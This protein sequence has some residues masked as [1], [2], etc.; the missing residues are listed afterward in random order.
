MRHFPTMLREGP[1]Q[2]AKA[3][4]KTAEAIIINRDLCRTKTNGMTGG[5]SILRGHNRWKRRANRAIVCRQA[6]CF[7][8]INPLI[9]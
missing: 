2:L 8:E 5:D 3:P 7:F 1:P 4:S 9:L 6:F